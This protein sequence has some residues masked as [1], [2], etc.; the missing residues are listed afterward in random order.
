MFITMHCMGMPFNG[1][2]LEKHSLGGSESACYYVAKE[3]AARG[4]KVI[5]FTTNPEEGD[6]DGVRYRWMGNPT[7]ASPMGERFGFYAENTPQDVL[8]MQ[9]H[10]HAFRFP[11]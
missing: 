6:W 7:E 4:H 9:R 5:V 11:C 10:P 8:I 3:L 2:T 1:E